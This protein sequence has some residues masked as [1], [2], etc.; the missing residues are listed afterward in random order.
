[1]TIEQYYKD[2]KE[3]APVQSSTGNTICGAE[4]AS[5]AIG[6]YITVPTLMYTGLVRDSELLAT[7]IRIL[8][9]KRIAYYGKLDSL[10]AVLDLPYE[11]GG[12]PA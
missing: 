10:A 12:E 11:E 7:A 5:S 6:E 9:D 4:C 3:P 8:M 2:K 1:M